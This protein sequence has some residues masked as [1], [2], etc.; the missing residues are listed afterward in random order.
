[1][2]WCTFSKKALASSSVFHLWY[3][4]LYHSLAHFIQLGMECRVLFKAQKNQLNSKLKEYLESWTKRCS[5][6]IQWRKFT[7][8][9]K[10]DSFRECFTEDFWRFSTPNVKIC[11]LGSR[12]R[13]WLQIQALKEFFLKFPNFLRP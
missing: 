10:I 8:Q 13:T 3:C 11:M 9:S 2:W 6:Q 1:M 5:F 12:L 7:K 4:Y